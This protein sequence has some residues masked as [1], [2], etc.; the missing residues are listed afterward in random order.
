[1]RFGGGGALQREILRIRGEFWR[2]L[3]RPLAFPAEKPML[4]RLAALFVTALLLPQTAT[5]DFCPCLGD[6]N[7]DG[8]V[9]ASDLAILL[10]EWG[11][12]GPVGDLNF[13][14]FVDAADLAILLGAWGACPVVPVNDTCATPITVDGFGVEVPFCTV[15]ASTS[16]SQ[17]GGCDIRGNLQNDVFFVYHATS[18]GHYR[19][20]VF[21]ATFDARALVYSAPTL[22]SVCAA[23]QGGGTLL[24][25]THRVI[26]TSIDPTGNGRYVEFDLDANEQILVRVGSPTGAVGYGTLQVERVNPGWSPCE[27]LEFFTGGGGGSTSIGT[28]EENYPSDF[29]SGCIDLTGVQDEWHSFESACSQNFNLRISTCTGFSFCDT[30]LAVYVGDSCGNLFEVACEDD[31]CTFDDQLH[32]EKIVLEDCTPNT[33]YFIRLSHFPGTPLGQIGLQFQVETICP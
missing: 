22:Q 7:A 15:M 26:P 29:P 31:N 12:T 30:V 3:T 33:K 19:A 16:L 14:A 1:V 17:S 23:A 18:A 32:L 28:L 9:D 24:G 4:K 11:E 5:A 27:P 2:D 6:L 13:N 8:L 10:G 21:D 20:K 25:C